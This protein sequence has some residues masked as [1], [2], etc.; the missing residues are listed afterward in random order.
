MTLSSTVVG[1][2]DLF[3]ELDKS[4]LDTIADL[5]RVKYVD[6]G[7]YIISASSGGSDVFFL[8]SG[9]VRVCFFAENGKQVHF[10]ELLAGMMFGELAAIDDKGRSSDCISIVDCQLGILGA[11][12]FRMLIA[13]YRPVQDAVLKRLAAMVRVNM[14]KVYEFAAFSVSQRIRFELLRMASEA[15]ASKGP[16]V[17]K[18]VPTHA[19]LASRVSTHREAVT[20]ELNALINKGTISWTHSEH[21]IHDVVALSDTP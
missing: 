10:D 21:I 15:P 14:R 9:K 5:M 2:F 7:Q 20:R 12:E 8:I 6:K 1:Q 16:I 4:A 17:L 18:N 19:E 3:R 13:Q 11:E